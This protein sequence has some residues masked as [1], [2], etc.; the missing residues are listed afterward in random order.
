MQ[1]GLL[2]NFGGVGKRDKNRKMERTYMSI[3]KDLDKY[4]VELSYNGVPCGY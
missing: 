3:Y 1:E 4:I 2:E